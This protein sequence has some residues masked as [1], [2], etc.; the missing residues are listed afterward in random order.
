MIHML[1]NLGQSIVKF[2]NSCIIIKFNLF[3][4]CFFWKKIIIIGCLFILFLL[5]LQFPG[6]L[7]LLS[8]MHGTLLGTSSNF[9]STTRR[10]RVL[11]HTAWMP[12]SWSFFSM[13]CLY[14]ISFA[15]VLP[16]YMTSFPLVY[17]VNLLLKLSFMKINRNI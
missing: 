16:R 3:D 12:F 14:F 4:F 11:N 13:I 2:F 7:I 10:V 9:L 17:Y 6:L 1:L 8:F 5:N 15:D